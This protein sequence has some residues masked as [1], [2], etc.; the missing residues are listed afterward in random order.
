M[1]Y[2]GIP[3]RFFDRLTV[4][5]Q[6]PVSQT[7]TRKTFFGRLGAIFTAS[8]VAPKLFAKSATKAVVHPSGRTKFELKPEARA[9]ARDTDSL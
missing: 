3:D 1:F 7:H 8:V 5:T 9:I 2:F 4:T 6:Q